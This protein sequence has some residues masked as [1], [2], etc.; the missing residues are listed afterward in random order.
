ME[1]RGNETILVVEDQPEVCEV[2]TTMLRGFGFH[3][4]ATLTPSEAIEIAS[5]P[6]IHIDLLISDDFLP[7]M[8]GPQLADRIRSL[9]P[10]IRILFMTG[11]IENERLENYPEADLIEKP[12]HPLDLRAKV[13]EVLDRRRAA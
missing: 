9:R 3:V 13:R 12:F 5:N 10:S 8:R 6:A 1:I 2:V 11:S 4:L 7:E